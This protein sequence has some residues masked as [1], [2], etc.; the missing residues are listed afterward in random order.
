MV[1]VKLG[2]V[3]LSCCKVGSCTKRGSTNRILYNW[4]VVNVRVVEMGVYKKK[5]VVQKGR[6]GNGVAPQKQL[7]W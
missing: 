4:S 3:Y 7:I 5:G 2:V 1:V 6:C